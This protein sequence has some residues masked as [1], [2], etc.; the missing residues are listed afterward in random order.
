[1]NDKN[2]ASK[3]SGNFSQKSMEKNYKES[4]KDE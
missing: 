2:I 4:I 1:M 3:S